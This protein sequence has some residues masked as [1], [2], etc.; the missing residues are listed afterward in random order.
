[1]LYGVLYGVLRGSFWTREMVK[2][3]DPRLKPGAGRYDMRRVHTHPHVW[4][5]DNA[6]KEARFLP[7]LKTRG[8]RA[9]K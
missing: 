7:G 6:A 4:Q 8:L 9:R 5:V 3:N 1:M 2:V